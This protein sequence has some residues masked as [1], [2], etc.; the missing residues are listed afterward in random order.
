M[1]R[2]GGKGY[3]GIM[4]AS[5]VTAPIGRGKKP[6]ISRA[7]H[8][9]TRFRQALLN[10][11]GLPDYP[12]ELQEALDDCTDKQRHFVLLA[13]SGM[14]PSE[15]YT[16]SYDVRTNKDA[17]TLS[18]DAYNVA[19]KPYVAKALSIAKQWLDT[20]WLLDA[21]QTVDWAVS[22]LYDIAE[23]APKHSDRLKATELLL[24]KHGELVDRKVVTH[25]DGTEADTQEALLKSIL[26]DLDALPVLETPTIAA[27]AQPNGRPESCPRCGGAMVDV[28][29][30]GDG[31]G[32]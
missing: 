17:Q 23:H 4:L 14:S 31:D 30:S 32:I 11:E 9:Q 20:N 22:N 19:Q 25:I 6:T 26:A 29:V 10:N 28:D 8:A 12:R 21:V 18:T 24:R 2:R 13:A 15:A 7:K 16:R 1:T 27:L 3:K 5:A